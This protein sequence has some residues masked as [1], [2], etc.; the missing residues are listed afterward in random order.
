M[1]SL[2]NYYAGGAYLEEMNPLSIYSGK[3]T[4]E[5]EKTFAEMKTG[6]VDPV[7]LIDVNLHTETSDSNSASTCPDMNCNIQVS[8]KG[9]NERSHHWNSSPPSDSHHDTPSTGSHTGLSA[10]PRL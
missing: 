2:V 9:G 8:S 7:T 5:F 6:N 3:S 1:I 10:P 4:K